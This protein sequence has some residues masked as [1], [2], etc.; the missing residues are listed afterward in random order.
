MQHVPFVLPTLKYSTAR[1][2]KRNAR[3]ENVFPVAIAGSRHHVL[4]HS[5][6]SRYLPKTEVFGIMLAKLKL[7][8]VDEMEVLRVGNFP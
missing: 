6:L 8:E 2:E 1:S 3:A 5:A 7:G 4:T